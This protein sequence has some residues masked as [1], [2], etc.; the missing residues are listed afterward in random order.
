MKNGSGSGPIGGG[1]DSPVMRRASG[2][3]HD[4]AQSR[5]S[6]Q[7][8]PSSSVRA[9]TSRF[10]AA[11][12]RSEVPAIPSS[13]RQGAPVN[14]RH[15][16]VEDALD[17]LCRTSTRVCSA[18]PSF[19]VSIDLARAPRSGSRGAHSSPRGTRIRTAP[20]RSASEESSA[21]TAATTPSGRRS[22]W[23]IRACPRQR[24]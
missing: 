10:S 4:C 18:S 17:C 7:P 15:G 21:S 5:G 9:R 8:P 6:H 23:S 13:L 12:T 14:R 16:H 2:Y 19:I 1:G 24:V 22:S 3:R 11:T 20:R